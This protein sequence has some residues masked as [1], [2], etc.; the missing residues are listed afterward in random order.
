MIQ[1]GCI[2]KIH[3]NTG[4]NKIKIIG[5]LNRKKR[6]PKVGDVIIGSIQKTISPVYKKSSIVTALLIKTKKALIRKD[7]STLS[8]LENAAVI[9]DKGGT[10]KGT[11]IFGPVP[12]EIKVINKKIASLTNNFI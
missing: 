12:I 4:I 1:I 9:I 7:G 6:I 11:H 10:P 8:Y 3:D 2:L 5:V